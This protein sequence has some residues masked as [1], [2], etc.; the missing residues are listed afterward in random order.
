MKTIL[1]TALLAG[2]TT[3]AHAGLS[4]STYDDLSE[5]FKGDTFS[6]NGVTYSNV[7]NTGGVFPNGD[8][9]TSADIGDQV[10]VEDATLL[11]NDFPSWGSADKALTF[12]TAFIP[13]DNLS[14]GAIAKVDMTLDEVADF[15][16]LEMA[17]FELGP[18]GG[19]TYSL[20]AYL[21]GQHVGTDSFVIAGNDP[22]ERDEIAFATMVI[23]GV[24]FDTL[25]LTATFGGEFSAPRILIDDLS[26]NTVPAPASAGIALGLAGLASRRRR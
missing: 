13:G 4:V 3:A 1:S 8:M 2:L 6:Y 21:N 7:N 16:S 9:F 19:I 23:D 14:L 26:I 5:G 18:W 10:I 24:R 11:Y 22:D 25:K 20:D 17:Y 12:G 15:A